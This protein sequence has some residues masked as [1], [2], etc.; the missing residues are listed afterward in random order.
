MNAGNGNAA[1][2]LDWSLRPRD[3][4]LQR[5]T[6]MT[7][8]EAADADMG[9]LYQRQ[10]AN[11]TRDILAAQTRTRLGRNAT[12]TERAQYTP[13][14]TARAIAALEQAPTQ[15]DATGAQVNPHAAR[16]GELRAG[17]N[18][19]RHYAMAD[20]L[21]VEQSA[22]YAPRDNA[23]YCNIYATDMING[24]GGYIPRTW[25]TPQAQ[26]RIRRGARVVSE[27]EYNAM[28]AADRRNA[29]APV[30][31]ETV[32]EMNANSLNAW[33]R[34]HG[35]NYGWTQA[36]DMNAAQEAINTGSMGVL[37]AANRDARR[38][39][40]IS[41][42]MPE[43]EAHRADRTDGSVTVP[44]QSQAGS[45]N[46]RVGTGG[47]QGGQGSQWWQDDNHRNGAAWIYTPPRDDEQGAQPV[48]NPGAVQPQRPEAQPQRRPQRQEREGD[49]PARGAVPAPDEVPG[50]RGPQGRDEQRAAPGRR[51]GPLDGP[52][53]R[54]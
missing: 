14:N 46:R 51:P 23:T 34:E 43:T 18:T 15:A 49:A 48:A 28:S 52:P 9:T 26:E 24:M 44:L 29:V 4:S 35:A 54:R 5:P 36:A 38:S 7:A 40:H 2:P 8:A 10:L 1:R 20:T 53:R 39:G 45:V 6:G 25:W 30:Y 33:F 16:L 47:R 32:N 50:F 41:V 17:L 37:S 11:Q 31:G 13:E 3:I 22:R 21:N 12:E 42:L 27:A 19:S